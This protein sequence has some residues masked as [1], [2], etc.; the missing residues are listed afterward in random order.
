MSADSTKSEVCHAH[1]N[2]KDVIS[3]VRENELRYYNRNN[4]TEMKGFSLKEKVS[5]GAIKKE[6][7]SNRD[8]D[9][10]DI[11]NLYHKGN[12]LLTS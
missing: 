4:I 5:W 12:S 8:D 3:Y 6:F 9:Q 11:F 10:S 2:F 1:Y 7:H